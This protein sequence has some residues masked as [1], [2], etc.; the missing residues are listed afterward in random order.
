MRPLLTHRGKVQKT[1]LYK[2]DTSH[3]LE[4]CSSFKFV[5]PNLHNCGWRRSHTSVSGKTHEF[6]NRE[7]KAKLHYEESFS[8]PVAG[9]R[10]CLRVGNVGERKVMMLKM[11]TG[12]FPR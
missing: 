6:G 3:P 9:T 10:K 7:G 2:K 4:F 5:T 12:V 8:P 1:S 11:V